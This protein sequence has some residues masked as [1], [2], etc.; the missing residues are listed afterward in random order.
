MASNVKQN[1]LSIILVAG[2]VA[3]ALALWDT[4]PS[5]LI[6]S[7]FDAQTEHFP[8][9]K[10]QDARTQHFD[11]SGQLSYEFF[12]REML[13]YRKNANLTQEDDFTTMA[14]PELTL[15]TEG[16]PWR[17]LAKNGRI[18]EF[19]AKLTL[20]GEVTIWQTQDNGDTT[21]LMTER[22]VLYP[23][24]KRIDTEQAVEIRSPL[25]TMTAVGM[26][27]NLETRNIKLL[28]QVRGRYEPI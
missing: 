1:S 24:S 2:L 17:V 23:Q 21:K 18:T 28:E 26:E 15:Y 27:V 8:Y 16:Q 5:S 4:D 19:G 14:Q 7:A 3:L 20:S 22:L 12:A 11:Q 25:G 13:H 10:L 6:P 9:A